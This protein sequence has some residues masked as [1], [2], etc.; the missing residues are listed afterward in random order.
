MAEAV[1]SMLVL[2]VLEVKAQKY[3]GKKGWREWGG[4]GEKRKDEKIA[5]S[6]LE[7]LREQCFLRKHLKRV[8]KHCM[9]KNQQENPNKSWLNKKELTVSL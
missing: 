8:C 7:I 9:V 2:L 4:G 5:F 6:L 1:V 3:L